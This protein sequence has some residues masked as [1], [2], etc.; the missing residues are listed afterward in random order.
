MSS[1]TT[2]RRIIFTAA[3]PSGR[4][5]TVHMTKVKPRPFAT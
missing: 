4:P 1:L 3:M 5:A 2:G